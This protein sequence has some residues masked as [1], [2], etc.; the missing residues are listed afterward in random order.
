MSG[1]IINL[2]RN[3]QVESAKNRLSSWDEKGQPLL[4]E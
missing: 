1:N 3:L 4:V 2:C